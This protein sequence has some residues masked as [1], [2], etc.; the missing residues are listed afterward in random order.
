VAPEALLA[1]DPDQVLLML[2]DLLGELRDAWPRLAHRW[3]VYGA[4]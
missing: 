3:V 1:G 2:P 4:R